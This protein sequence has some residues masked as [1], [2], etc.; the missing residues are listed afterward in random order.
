ML[1]SVFYAKSSMHRPQVM[2]KIGWGCDGL[3]YQLLP[4]DF[5]ADGQC[6][7]G[8]DEKMDLISEFPASCIHPPLNN[9][10]A[11]ELLYPGCSCIMEESMRMAQ[12]SADLTGERTLVVMHVA[13]PPR[14]MSRDTGDG[15]RRELERLFGL[16]PSVDI[17]A[18]N[19]TPFRNLNTG[20]SDFCN[21]YYDAN[22]RFV[23]HFG[24]EGRLFTCLDICHALL[25]AMYLDALGKVWD[26]ENGLPFDYSLDTYFEMNR[27]KIGLI[28]L[29]G[30]AGNGYGEG[31]G[32]GFDH[33]SGEGMD[34]LEDVFDL[35]SATGLSCPVTIEVREDDFL[36][37]DIYG[38]SK[39]AIEWL[40]DQRRGS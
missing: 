16:F 13:H 14:E 29:A 37:S 40:L 4:E 35:Y 25:S 9:S 1:P 22:V 33:R 7:L 36:E 15:M 11:E 21:G 5:S 34:L 26:P 12:A 3:E 8:R 39:V 19:I 20:I 2:S 27:K 31:H 18:E 10:N 23:E 32:T 38:R 24:F 6:L 28:H 30:C 17:V